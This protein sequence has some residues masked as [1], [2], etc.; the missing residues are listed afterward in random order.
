MAIGLVIVYSIRQFIRYGGKDVDRIVEMKNIIKEFPGV[1]A[2]DGGQFDL[3]EGEIHALIG[4]NGAGK[5]TMMKILYGLYTPD[6][7]TITV[8]GQEY[9]GLT[10][11]QAIDLG[12]GMV[13]QEF[14]LVEEMTVLENIIL[15]F[16]PKKSGNRIDFKK[17]VEKIEY[18]IEN[19]GLDIQLNKKVR[20]IS[21][22]EA[23]RVEIIKT[24]YR[25]ADILILDE[26]T[27]VLTPQET[28]K[29]FEIFNNLRE[30]NRSIIFI[31]H[32]LNEIMEI[33]DRITVMRHGKHVGTVNKE[34]TTIPEIAKMMV[35]REV[36][37]NIRRKKPEVGEVLLSVKDVYV[38][39]ERELSKIKGISFELHRG[40]VLGIAG[41]DGNGQSE[42]VEAITG[43]RE[44]E[45]GDII[46]KGKSIKNLSPAQIRKL[47]I[48]HIPEDRNR[49]GLN[50]PFTIRENLIADK[51]E[52]KEFSDWI[53]LNEKKIRE[54]AE[55]LVEKF[56]IR[57]ANID[58]SAQ[59]LSGGNAQKIVV[60]REIANEGDLLIASQPTRGV[61]IGSI[62]SIRRVL[63]DLKK[64]GVGIL[65]ISADLEEILSLSDRIAVMYE[66]RITGVLDNEQATE[67]NLGLL[68]T[69]GRIE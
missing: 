19:Y 17:A 1:K 14:M 57:P 8:K 39:G 69:G 10:T 66:G 7:G 23:Q 27:A 58:L 62:E 12:I 45:K 32:K 51:F 4:E 5:S 21:V 35:G 52:D 22:G 53:V 25:G 33:C 16:E 28:E 65:L 24:L 56:D 11:K 29:L 26:P 61:D 2:V 44:V 15:G 49:R 68:M 18:Y 46:F 3:K 37:L 50:R 48:S 67:E 60:A 42:I 34:D 31:S 36:F 20:D 63:N 47:G 30:D 59:N 6:G 13:H 54:F 40:E 41:V 43:L 55:D 38:P 9:G 64:K